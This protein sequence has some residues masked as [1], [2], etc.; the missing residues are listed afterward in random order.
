[1]AGEEVSLVVGH[2]KVEEPSGHLVRDI[3]RQSNRRSQAAGP[4]QA[5]WESCLSHDIN[6]TDR[7]GGKRALGHHPLGEKL[8]KATQKIKS[9]RMEKQERLVCQKPVQKPQQEPWGSPA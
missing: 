8:L 4:S 9:E 5:N 6:V 2:A 7:K 3:G 1:M